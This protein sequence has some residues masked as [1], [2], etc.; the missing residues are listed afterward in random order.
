MRVV[1]YFNTEIKH[2]KDFKAI[3]DLYNDNKKAFRIGGV[4]LVMVVLS[5]IGA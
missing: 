4:I 5:L 3:E 1:F 2:M